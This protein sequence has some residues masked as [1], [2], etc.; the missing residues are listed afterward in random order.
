MDGSALLVVECGADWTQW[1]RT[2]G[3]LGPPIIA[4]IQEREESVDEFAARVRAR[5]ERL[6]ERGAG[7]RRLTLLG[8][9]D[10]EI[11]TL[12]ARL[13]ILHKA[14]ESSP[15]VAVE[16]HLDATRPPREAVAEYVGSAHRTHQ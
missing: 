1:M 8:A 13:D 10:W 14:R 5:I 6:L 11:S 9:N 2:A 3:Q 15:N 4:L 7:I 12:R 16:L